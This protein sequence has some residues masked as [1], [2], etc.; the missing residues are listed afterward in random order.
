MKILKKQLHNK[1]K[2]E[3]ISI[4]KGL[5][6]KRYS[7]KNKKEL[8]QLINSFLNSDSEKVV[9][10]ESEGIW[11]KYIDG[12]VRVIVVIVASI[13][14]IVKF[15]IP[16]N[17]CDVE[18][19]CEVKESTFIANDSL[20]NILLLPF[21]P[22]KNCIIENTDYERQIIE[23]FDSIKN[24]HNY[25]ISIHLNNN[26]NCP[27]TYEEVQKIGEKEN[28]NFVI[29]GYYDEECDD[30]VKIRLKYKLIDS[31]DLKI[32]KEGDTKYHTIEN[33]KVLKSGVLQK[34]MDYIIKMTL[35]F[36]EARK[37]EITNTLKILKTI[38]T[39]DCD[40][41][42]LN[43]FGECYYHLEEIEKTDSIYSKLN[44]CY[45]E[46]LYY[47]YFKGVIRSRYENFDDALPFYYKVID[48]DSMYFEARRNILY[49]L[50]MSGRM[51]QVKEHL[52]FL[53]RHKMITYDILY[54]SGE[55]L[56]SLG[57]IEDAVKN[58]NIVIENER[59]HSGA[60][61][62]LSSI[63]F[64]SCDTLK[65]FQIADTLF[66]YNPNNVA[67]FNRRIGKHLLQF[68]I[69]SVQKYLKLGLDKF[70]NNE[71]LLNIKKE[72]F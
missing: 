63:Y 22:D 24:I 58:F 21:H 28:A 27:R 59:G 23:R 47:I 72:F 9:K 32:N 54:F 60:L 56:K 37:L 53:K 46:E 4:A 2:I 45:P 16:Q 5:G 17:D 55:Y 31:I 65:A 33:F 38:E 62:A 52:V 12:R 44:N 40:S 51:D 70:P 71:Y 30:R 69:D 26:Y 50:I 49:C 13:L 6:I 20:F 42:V 35:A 14:A 25:K 36:Y 48:L 64:N 7:N 11:K 19:I 3:L 34:N 39:N 68:E 41:I 15:L 61:I 10:K 8:I 57:Y 67:S 43:S 1:T 18:Q 66:K 29:W